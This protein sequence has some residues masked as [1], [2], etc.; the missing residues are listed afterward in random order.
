MTAHLNEP[1][2]RITSAAS[3]GAA[4]RHYRRSAGLTQAEVAERV[5]LRRRYLSELESDEQTERLDHIV[6][7]LRALGVRLTCSY[8]EW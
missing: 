6:R 5:G 1:P 3:I 4:I 2:F 8:E 7:V